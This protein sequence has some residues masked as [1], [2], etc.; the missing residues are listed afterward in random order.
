MSFAGSES[1]AVDEVDEEAEPWFARWFGEEYLHLYPHRDQE[2]AN[3]GVALILAQIQLS[4]GDRVLDLGCGAGRH[5]R[6]FE[7]HALRGVGLDL[8][9]PLLRRSRA[10]GT[11]APL[12]RGDIRHLPFASGAF[13]AATSAIMRTAASFPSLDVFFRVC[14]FTPSKADLRPQLKSGALGDRAL[15]S[16]QTGGA[17]SPSTPKKGRLH[18][19][20]I[21]RGF[22]AVRR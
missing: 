4:E 14:I 9:L 18:F 13:D 15:P 1:E 21:Y 17:G 8:S 12:V 11:A 22:H 16:F 2:E 19:V 7:A 20:V 10:K 3:R 6:A 5:L